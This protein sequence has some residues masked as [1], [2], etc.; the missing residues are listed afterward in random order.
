MSTAIVDKQLFETKLK[1]GSSKETV[2]TEI[3]K[4]C[5]TDVEAHAAVAAMS[6][7]AAKGKSSTA[8]DSTI[9]AT[10]TLDF[11]DAIPHEEII[12]HKKA[13][14]R[15]FE[16]LGPRATPSEQAAIAS[17]PR[18]DLIREWSL[19]VHMK[20]M[21][22][23]MSLLGTQYVAGDWASQEDASRKAFGVSSENYASGYRSLEKKLSPPQKS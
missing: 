1:P 2:T 10:I 16:N 5:K 8:V 21:T 15:A 13:L 4:K 14:E 18:D 19:K 12:S 7:D 17:T 11:D 20:K 22:Q 3:E 23:N 6:K 9:P